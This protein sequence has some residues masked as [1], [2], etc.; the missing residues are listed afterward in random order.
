MSNENY[1]DLYKNKISHELALEILEEIAKSIGTSLYSMTGMS[2]YDHLGIEFGLG[3]LV[4]NIRRI[5][6]DAKEYYE[7]RKILKKVVS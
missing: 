3:N 4:N 5:N 2:E 6:S 1:T 7:L